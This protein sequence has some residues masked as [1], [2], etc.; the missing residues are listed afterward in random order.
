MLPGTTKHNFFL[1]VD[2]YIMLEKVNF[3]IL[4]NTS[5][6]YMHVSPS[7]SSSYNRAKWMFY[8]ARA[9]VLSSNMDI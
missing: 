1:Y 6:I 3:E 7:W 4:M 8:E 2:M 5:T 9:H